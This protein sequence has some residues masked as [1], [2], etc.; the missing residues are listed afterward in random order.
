MLAVAIFLVTFVVG[1][2]VVY[3]RLVGGTG[4]TPGAP[5]APLGSRFSTPLVLGVAAVFAGSLGSALVA[6]HLYFVAI[7]LLFAARFLVR[8]GI[9][10]FIRSSGFSL[11][12]SILPIGLLAAT[13]FLLSKATPEI[14]LLIATAAALILALLLFMPQPAPSLQEPPPLPI[15]PPLPPARLKVSG[16]NRWLC[17]LF[18]AL[19]VAGVNLH[20][21]LVAALFAIP[22]AYFFYRLFA[23]I[24]PQLGV[25]PLAGVP[26]VLILASSLWL[27]EHGHFGEGVLIFFATVATF[28]VLARK[29]VSQP[30]A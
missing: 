21:Y 4:S 22:A 25:H 8:R 30:A 12:N 18:G 5:S 2:Y 6:Y 29:A 11:K 28:A 14:A 23:E 16:T 17:I 19:T 26:A 15:P 27:I 3:P 20:L 9:R 24:A 13:L 10:L 7:I 1:Y